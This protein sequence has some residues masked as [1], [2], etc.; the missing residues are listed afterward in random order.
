MLQNEFF[1]VQ[2]FNPDLPEETWELVFE[3]T[4]S[5]A[6][7][8]SLGWGKYKI[9]FSGGGGSGGAGSATHSNYQNWARDGAPGEE[10]YIITRI[11]YGSTRVYSG[12][13]GEGGKSS[14]AYARYSQAVDATATAGNA[15]SGYENGTKGGAKTGKGEGLSDCSAAAGGAGGG[16]TSLQL[17]DSGGT[18]FAEGGNGGQASADQIGSVSAGVGG[19]GGTSSGTGAAGGAGAFGY[20]SAATSGAGTDGYIKIYK[21]NIYPNAN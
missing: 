7:S 9:V 2:S 16:S 17:G 8:Q 15:G 13:I 12:I 20:K 4:T 10:S 14:Y 3:K 6:Y 1:R 18:I 11:G 21:S 19:S 5:G